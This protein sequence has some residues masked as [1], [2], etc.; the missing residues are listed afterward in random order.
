L[1]YWHSLAQLRGERVFRRDGWQQTCRPEVGGDGDCSG[2]GS[3]PGVSMRGKAMKR[4]GDRIVFV[5][6]IVMSD[7]PFPT[8]AAAHAQCG[9]R[10]RETSYVVAVYDARVVCCALQSWIDE[11]I[12]WDPN[13][14]NQLRIFRM[15]ANKLWLPDIVLYNRWVDQRLARGAAWLHNETGRLA[16]IRVYPIRTRHLS[17]PFVVTLRFA[18][19]S[20]R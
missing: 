20:V 3:L 4:S 12:R 16:E 11:R 5:R 13:D 14:Y 18:R 2:R 7:C 15:P 19:S 8:A 9:Q 6:C 10:T 17:I 1:E